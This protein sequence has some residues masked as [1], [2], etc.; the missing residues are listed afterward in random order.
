[1]NSLSPRIAG[2]FQVS[3]TVI[4]MIPLALMAVIGTIAGLTNGRM[5]ANFTATAVSTGASSSGGLMKEGK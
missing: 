1:M 5:A 3:T 2:K 4:K